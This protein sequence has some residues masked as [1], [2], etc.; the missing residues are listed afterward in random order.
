[1]TVAE[2]LDRVSSAELTEW[3]AYERMT[4][5]LGQQ[6]DDMNAGIITAMIANVNRKKGS[7][8]R[9]PAEFIPRWDRPKARTPNQ[10]ANA[11][12]TMTRKLGGKI[13]RPGDDE[14]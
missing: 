11:L 8:E 10:M 12:K 5:P 7:R 2:L 9:K 13:R 3:V 14:G 6:R 4:G 1:M